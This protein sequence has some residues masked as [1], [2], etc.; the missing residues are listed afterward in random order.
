MGVSSPSNSETTPLIMASHSRSAL[1]TM[2]SNT[3]CDVGWRA[4]DDPQDL[5]GGRLL[6]QR[7]GEVVVARL[8]LLEQP[9]VL[10]RDDRLV[11]EGLEQRD[12]RP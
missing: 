4:A 2:M 8:Q 5:A 3:G 6:L 1:P 12:L 9:H 11:G 10:D 7:L